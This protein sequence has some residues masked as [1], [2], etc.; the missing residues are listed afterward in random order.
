MDIANESESILAEARHALSP[1]ATYTSDKVYLIYPTT[2]SIEVTVTPA[3][4]GRS[5]TFLWTRPAY[6]VEFLGANLFNTL[7]LATSS[8]NR[9][10]GKM[11]YR[12]VFSFPDDIR[13]NTSVPAHH[14]S[15][16]AHQDINILAFERQEATVV[17]LTSG[18]GKNP[19][20][21]PVN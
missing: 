15:V 17:S 13:V 21:F 8:H 4:D 10:L 7:N 20:P 11:E 16:P 9:A 2:P 12:S 6:S 3:P 14:Y 5:A 18:G 19:R 1:L